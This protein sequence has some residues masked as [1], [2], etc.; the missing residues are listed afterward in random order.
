MI[1]C[2]SPLRRHQSR[3]L[4]FGCWILEAGHWILDTGYLMLTNPAESALRPHRAIPSANTPAQA[5]FSRTTYHDPQSAGAAEDAGWV[6]ECV[7]RM[8][9]SAASCGPPSDR[10]GE[11]RRNAIHAPSTGLEP[12]GAGDDVIPGIVG[13]VEHW[14]DGAFEDIISNIV[15]PTRD[16]RPAGSPEMIEDSVV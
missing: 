10:H 11:M 7:R 9:R 4:D 16:I 3:I 15:C 1:L 14:D 6:A 8:G 2:V 12:G 5:L 13:V